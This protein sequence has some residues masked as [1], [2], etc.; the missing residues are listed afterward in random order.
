MTMVTELKMCGIV[1]KSLG[2]SKFLFVF[3]L[4][5]SYV[6]LPI[7]IIWGGG[8]R[9]IYCKH[10]KLYTTLPKC[11]IV[12][13][14]DMVWH[15]HW[16]NIRMEPYRGKQLADSRWRICL[17]RPNNW[18]NQYLSTDIEGSYFISN[19]CY[20]ECI[21]CSL[22][23]IMST[24]KTWGFWWYKKKHLSVFKLLKSNRKA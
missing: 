13:N 23:N 14:H 4:Y 2:F 19:K 5:A 20:S 10:F 11:C 3:K 7:D 15:M 24:Q 21:K 22:S 1:K 17:A 9:G 16:M 8:W 18:L 6:S 12:S